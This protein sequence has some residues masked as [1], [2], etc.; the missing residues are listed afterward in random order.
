MLS[1]YVQNVCLR[2]KRESITVCAVVRVCV[3][4]QEKQWASGFNHCSQS[5]SSNLP[6]GFSL[7][8]LE[9]NTSCRALV[10][11]PN[12]THN[13]RRYM[14]LAPGHHCEWKKAD[15]SVSFYRCS[16]SSDKDMSTSGCVLFNFFREKKTTF[17][18]S[19]FKHNEVPV[20]SNTSKH[21]FC[22]L[23]PPPVP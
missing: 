14:D 10:G 20:K 5:S 18:A 15:F 13:A 16:C 3:C 2:V 19:T 1:E 4:G 17:P 6:H 12:N 7:F 11:V 21:A 9:V 23:G 8:S 22:H